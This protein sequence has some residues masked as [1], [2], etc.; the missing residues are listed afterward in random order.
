MPSSAPGSGSKFARNS[1]AE[2][3]ER[4][5]LYDA[6]YSDVDIGKAVGRRACSIW[7]W[8]RTRGLPALYS[9]RDPAT[10]AAL[11]ERLALYKQ[12]L[13]DRAIARIQ[14]VGRT[15]VRAWRYRRNLYRNDEPWHLRR[16]AGV[17]PATKT[18]RIESVADVSLD[19]PDAFGRARIDSLRDDSWSDWL[20][21]MGATVW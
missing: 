21:E 5:A 14:R 9:P 7:L 2:E 1:E 3:R 15:A 11:E 16:R 10:P 17:R 8:R 20:E 18:L 4:R 6:G 19:A 13:N 12:G